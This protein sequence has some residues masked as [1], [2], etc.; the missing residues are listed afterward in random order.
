MIPLFIECVRCVSICNFMLQLLFI[1][2]DG[3]QSVYIKAPVRLF[4]QATNF[5]SNALEKPALPLIRLKVNRFNFDVKIL[6]II[7][8]SINMSMKS[9]GGGVR[10]WLV[11][12]VD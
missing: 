2:A 10:D 8:A 7:G 4:K 6:K 1:D 12:F 5:Q 9:I 3:N 11:H